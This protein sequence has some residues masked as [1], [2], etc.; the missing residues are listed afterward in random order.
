MVPV[1]G[2][3]PPPAVA[4]RIPG[5]IASTRRLYQA[6][7]PW[8]RA[9]MLASRRSSR[10]TW[11]GM[12]RPCCGSSASARPRRCVRS[13]PPRPPCAV[14]A[15][16]GA[17]RTRFDA[18]ILAVDGDPIADPEALTASTRI[19][20]AA[21]LTGRGTDASPAAAVAITCR[22]RPERTGLGYSTGP[23]AG[24]AHR[25]RVLPPGGGRLSACAGAGKRNVLQP[26]L[27]AGERLAALA[28][29]GDQPQLLDTALLQGLGENLGAARGGRAQ[30]ISRIVHTDRELPAV[31]HRQA[32]AEACG[33]FET[34]V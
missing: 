23:D 9:P 1:P 28:G 25:R 14:W 15:P 21:P 13:P 34:V 19:F 30:E 32:G 24:P 16:Q 31:P 4:A 3:A 7:A 6:G 18:D 2:M 26:E 20:A 17:H 5:I 10:T 22:C 8:S 33:G 29:D 12:R 27:A 11:S